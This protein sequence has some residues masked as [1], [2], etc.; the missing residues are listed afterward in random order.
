[1]IDLHL[2]CDMV[3]EEDR[4]T[5]ANTQENTSVNGKCLPE[6]QVPLVLF[7][8][9]DQTAQGPKKRAQSDHLIVAEPNNSIIGFLRNR[10]HKTKGQSVQ[11]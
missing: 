7:A 11:I 6:K 2:L 9:D 5:Q 3:D 1:M 10:R 4:V 8:K